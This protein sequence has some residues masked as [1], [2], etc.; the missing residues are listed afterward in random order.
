MK[1]SELTE[2]APGYVLPPS[3][4]NE[5]VWDN[6]QPIKCEIELQLSPTLLSRDIGIL[7]SRKLL[8]LYYNTMFSEGKSTNCSWLCTLSL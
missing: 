7:E 3:P 4:A 6:I 1:S 5:I 8:L 2:K